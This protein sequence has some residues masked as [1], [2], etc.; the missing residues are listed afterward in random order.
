MGWQPWNIFTEKQTSWH[1]RFLAAG[2][3]I[4]SEGISDCRYFTA[5]D[6]ELGEAS[7]RLGIPVGVKETAF[8]LRKN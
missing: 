1:D 2:F 3:E 5:D 4:I 6:N 7:C 8:I